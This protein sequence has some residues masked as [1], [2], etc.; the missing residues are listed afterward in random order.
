[1]KDYADCYHTLGKKDYKV[2][3]DFKA[4]YGLGDY[5]SIALLQDQDNGSGKNFERFRN[6]KFKVLNYKKACKNAEK[7]VALSEYYDGYKRRSF[8]FSILHL[9]NHKNFDF[10]QLLS[11]L[12]YQQSRLVDCT[13]K[14]QYLL[15]LQNIYN[16]KSTKK[17]NLIYN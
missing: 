14:E 11:K 5:E 1:M 8:V 6:G 10:K 4:K 13:N 7:V 9:I 2:Y 16:Y 3:K 12:K 15:L 17:V